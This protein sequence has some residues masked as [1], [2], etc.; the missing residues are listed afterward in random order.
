M[1][2]K[3]KSKEILKYSNSDKEKITLILFLEFKIL[4]IRKLIVN[5]CLINFKRIFYYKKKLKQQSAK[6]FF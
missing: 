3:L 4:N 2:I 5:P 1:K 6:S